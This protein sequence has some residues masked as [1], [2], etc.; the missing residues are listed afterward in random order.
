MGIKDGKQVLSSITQLSIFDVACMAKGVANERG[1]DSP[2]IVADCSNIAYV[3]SKA[4]SI[5]VS[6]VTHLVKWANTGLIVIPVCDGHIRPVCKQATNERIANSDKKRIK[7]YKQ[8]KAI[9]KAKQQLI[10][11]PMDESQRQSLQKEITKMERSCKTNDTQSRSIIPKNF[12]EEMTRELYET[13][14]HST[15]PLTGGSVGNVVVA[16]FQADSYMAYQLLNN[17]AVMVETKDA[18]IPIISGDHCFAIKKFTNK[19]YEVVCTSESALKNAMQYLPKESKAVLTKALCPIFD[20]VKSHH[21]RALMMLILGCD[22]YGPGMKGTK[23]KKLVTLIESYNAT[24][25]DQLYVKLFYAFKTTNKL[26]DEVINTYIEALLY[27]P[28]N[29][30]PEIVDG[31]NSAITRTYLFGTPIKLP[32]YLEDFAVNEAFKSTSIFVGPDISICKGVGGSQHKF[33]SSDGVKQCFKCKAEVCS[34]C[35][36]DIANVTFCLSCYATESIVPQSGGVGSKSIAD[37]RQELVKENFDGAKDLDSDEVEDV[38]EM[39]EYLHHYRGK[40]VAVEYPLYATSEMINDASTEWDEIIEINFKEGG[41]FL[42]EPTLEA[43]HVPGVLDLFAALVR[44]ESGKKTEW[45]KD[46][47]IYDVLPS[48]FLRFASGS[49]I[50]SGYRILMRCVRHAFDSRAPSLDQHT[51][52]LILHQS[53]IGLH[54]NAAIPA[55]MKKKVYQTGIVVTAKD[56]IC[57]KCSC[58]CGSDGDQR[59]VCVHNLPLLF[60]LTLLLFE[61]LAEHMLLELAACMG[62]DIWDK[63][64]W[65]EDDIKS[66]KQSIITL[67]E[68]AGEPMGTHNSN[69]EIDDLLKTFVVGTERRKAWKQRIKTPPKPSELGPAHKFKFHST[70]KEASC[71]VKRCTDLSEQI[72]QEPS[73]TDG[74]DNTEVVTFTPNYYRIWCLVEAADCENVLGLEFAGFELLS[75]RSDKQAHSIDKLQRTIISKQAKKGWDELQGLAKKRS[76]RNIN[77]K[78]DNLPASTTQQHHFTPSKKRKQRTVSSIT[79]SPPKLLRRQNML[80]PTRE[81]KKR[82]STRCAKCNNNNVNSPGLKFHLIPTHPAK[83]MKPNTRRA[84]VIRQTGVKLLREET[85]D[86]VGESRFSEKKLYVCEDHMFE[87]VT[88]RKRVTH[89]DKVFVQKY[90]LTV[91]CGEGTKSSLSP[92]DDVSKGTGYDRALRRLIAEANTMEVTPDLHVQAEEWDKLYE[93]LQEEYEDIT[94]LKDRTNNLEEQKI[95][96]GAKLELVNANMV[97]ATKA[98]QQIAEETCQETNIPIN[99]SVQQAAGMVTQ[100]GNSESIKKPNRCFFHCDPIKHATARIHFEEDHIPSVYLG[101]PDNEVKRRTGFPS[102]ISLLSYMFIV[103]NGDIDVIKE[104]K[105]SLTW[106]EEWFLHFEYKWGKSL[107][108]LIDVCSMYRICSRDSQRIIDAKYDIE[109]CA[110]ISWPMYAWYEE[111][112]KMRSDNDTW[113]NKYM[114]MRPVMWDMTNIHAYAFTDADLQRFTFNQYYAENCLKGGIFTQCGGWHGVYDLWMGAV[115]DTDYNRRA[116]YVQQQEEFQNIDLVEG[117][118]IPFLNIYDKGYRAK[119]VAWKN[120][121][122]KVLQPYYANSDCRFNR[123]YSPASASIACDRGGNKRSTICQRQ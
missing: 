64:V 9:R 32:K 20:G 121:K 55:S 90:V 37:M 28:A 26:D 53:D 7:S 35:H 56:I 8:R 40:E 70:A 92:S 1:M 30:N 85:M 112:V 74:D 79:P 24:S 81:K 16:E 104:R 38:H 5:T 119:M 49:R 91:P 109:Y 98:V 11:D 63:S 71:A 120:G 17:K 118:V 96:L 39:M 66:M 115:S 114:G 108:R 75:M 10:S 73:D 13:A 62:A 76:I 59:V 45:I 95:V 77:R 51:A 61:D 123:I 60:L 93:Q 18:D 43:K 117:Q 12:A 113:K 97:H 102:E 48:L 46:S 103:C 94:S 4:A 122:Q 116:G 84:V 27:E 86:R 65:S 52:M 54:L 68:A 47:A 23:A 42:A 111:D 3:F 29:A 2:T 33:L 25:E 21:L 67:T 106:Y 6:V 58:Q 14:A 83:L 101:M 22:V 19:D 89:K 41:A 50:D 88:K 31:E 100:K 44:F 34:H 72:L 69:N 99:S 105:T 82:P 107:T 110:L 57:C 36:E 15:L 80:L 87:K 78:I